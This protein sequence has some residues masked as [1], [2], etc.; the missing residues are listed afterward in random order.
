MKPWTFA[1]ADRA[2]RARGWRCSHAKGSHYVYVKAG[3][4]RNLVIPYHG[5]NLSRIVQRTLMH[6]LRISP[7]DL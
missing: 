1:D 3:E 4:S 6:Q 5:G 7:R 2:A